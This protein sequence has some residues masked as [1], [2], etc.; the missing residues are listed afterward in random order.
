MD[1]GKFIYTKTP[2]GYSE[3]DK[4]KLAVYGIFETRSAKWDYF[5]ISFTDNGTNLSLTSDICKDSTRSTNY[6][7]IRT[8]GKRLKTV[9]EGKK[10][11]NEFCVK[12]ESGSNNTTA[13]MRKK[14]LEDILDEDE[15]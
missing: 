5:L 8:Y 11:I 3:G 12:W 15:K 6:T 7:H 1:K 9:D 4:I 10:F 13:E 2:K 14:K